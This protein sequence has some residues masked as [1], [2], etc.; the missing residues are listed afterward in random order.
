MVGS[1]GSELALWGWGGNS[2][3][4]LAPWKCMW[5]R[6]WHYGIG[7]CTVGSEGGAV[8]SELALE[9]GQALC[10]GRGAAGVA[11]AGGA[12]AGVA[13]SGDGRS[14]DGQSGDG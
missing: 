11:T 14:G 7:A 9:S 8:G 3:S 2:E 12:T 10:G 1:V 5:D 6:S 4:K 13:T